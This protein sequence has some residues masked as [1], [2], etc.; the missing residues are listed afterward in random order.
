MLFITVMP[1]TVHACNYNDMSVCFEHNDESVCLSMLMMSQ[2]VLSILVI[3]QLV[4][5]SW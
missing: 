1:Y 2:F 3:S 5:M 4:L